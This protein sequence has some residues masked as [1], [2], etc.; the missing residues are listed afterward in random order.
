M[1]WPSAGKTAGV[2]LGETSDLN[3][4]WSWGQ[5]QPL[6][7]KSSDYGAAGNGTA[8]DT[9]AIQD[10]LDDAYTTGAPVLIPPGT[11]KITG[12]GL[13]TH[14]GTSIIGAGSQQTTLTYTGTGTCLTISL[15]GT[16]TGGENAGTF[17][18]FSLDGYSAG[19]SAN[20]IL[21]GDLQGM[22]ARD[23]SAAGFGGNG[24]WI[25]NAS[26]NWSQFNWYEAI[27]LIQNGTAIRFDGGDIDYFFDLTIVTGAGQNGVIVTG[28]AA[29]Q[30]I[31]LRLGGSFYGATPNTAAVIAIDPGWV[32]GPTSYIQN[33]LCHIMAEAESPGTGHYTLHLGAHDSSF[34][35]TGIMWF[36]PGGIAFQGVYNPNWAIIGFSGLIQ[37]PVLGSMTPGHGLA[38]RG[39]MH[40]TSA[41]DTSTALYENNIYWQF[42]DITAAQLANGA[43]AL[44]F[45]GVDAG[46]G[47]RADL[48]LAQPSSGAAGTVT[49]PGNV[50]WPAGTPPSL[51]TVNGYVDHVRLTYVPGT[52]NWYGEL[53]GTHYA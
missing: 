16:F 5:G 3:W 41:G 49:W 46:W 15:D 6:N 40:L 44:V 48:F 34:T 30:G 25:K 21:Y 10:A 1:P 39:G 33:A 28:G 29:M 9:T 32:S 8:D 26:G 22:R 36:T 13:T 50:K 38:V 20:G 42:G 37:D 14:Q 4:L 12:T 7:V 19:S 35:G 11:Y 31:I 51:S 27:Y 52:G 17:T 24:I 43:N 23:I 45:N 2:S 53:A 18:G 47:K